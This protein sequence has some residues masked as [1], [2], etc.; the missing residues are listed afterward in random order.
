M[1]FDGPCTIAEIADETGLHYMTVQ[2][3]LRELRRAEA[4]HI[5]A[6]EKDKQGRDVIKVYAIGPGKDA[7][8][9]KLTPA[10]R[11]R[12]YKARLKEKATL[13]ATV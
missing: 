6:W 9:R 10:E 4:A 7:K 8:R 13:R 1:L 3:Y 12:T 11:Q 5:A 2:I